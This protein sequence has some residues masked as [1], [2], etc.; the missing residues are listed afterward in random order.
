[1]LSFLSNPRKA[2]KFAALSLGALWI[3][4]C[5]PTTSGNRGPAFDPGQPV[6]VA[7]LLPSGSGNAGDDTLARGL[8]Q[9]ADMAIADLAGSA[10]I[11]LRVYDVG[12]SPDLAAQMA[13]KAADD[14]ALIIL[15]PVYGDS[16]NAAGLAVKDRGLN[17]L[18]F[19][20]N[21]DIAGGNVFVLGQT[22]QNTANRLVAYAQ[23]QGKGAILIAHEQ[24]AQG[25]HGER[26]IT[27][28]AARAGARIVGSQPYAFSGP[29]VSAAVP[30]IAAAARADGASAIFLTAD[31]AGALPLL[32]QLLPEAGLGSGSIQYVG[33]TRWD[34]PPA[35][36]SLPGIQGGWFALPDP[37]LN[38][39][40]QSRYTNAYGEAPNP[41][42]GLAYDGIAAIGALVKSGRG[43][44]FSAQSLT[45]GAGFAGVTGVFRLKSD[46][47]NERGLAVAQISNG[48]AV[49]IDPA[50]RSFGGAGF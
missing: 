22:F 21:T 49:I 23:R 29:G 2:L 34:I 3:S 17:V 26:A 50:P 44:P 1:M 5:E 46:G 6:P 37:G 10:K 30:A 31:S 41:I 14:G 4:G 43:D 32:A 47:T 36:L 35:T 24:N 9:A 39:Q 28:A 40:F 12:A 18:S 15:G 11:D 42:A 7:L 45:Q 38:G 13:S 20:N 27:A 25:D 16:A 33:L 8:R 19:S 48:Q